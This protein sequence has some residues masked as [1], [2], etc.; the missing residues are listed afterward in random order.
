MEAIIT[1]ATILALYMSPVSNNHSKFLYN[2]DVENGRVNTMCVYEK[3]DCKL[4]AK[5]QY[6]FTYDS[7]DRLTSKEAYRWNS[8]KQVWQKAYVYTYTYA[9]NNIEIDQSMW[10]EE[11]NSYN[12]PCE[13]SIYS[14]LSNG[15]MSVKTFKTEGQDNDLSLSDQ[16]LLMGNEQ[17]L[18][19]M[20]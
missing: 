5:L 8:K 10:N 3:N 16:Y 14:T 6:K 19:A 13:K 15:V 12:S 20:M 1:A 9:N 17:E 11:A 4:N 2:A 18:M 7:Q